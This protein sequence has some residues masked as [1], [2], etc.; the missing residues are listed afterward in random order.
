M[1]PVP[2]VTIGFL[3][4]VQLQPDLARIVLVQSAMPSLTLASI[5]F[6]RYASDE[7][8]GAITTVFSTLFAMLTIPAVVM[9][10]SYI[11]QQHP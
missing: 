4:C 11:L 2:L 1:E 6:A 9:M 7:E 8:F 5:L 3:T 10:G